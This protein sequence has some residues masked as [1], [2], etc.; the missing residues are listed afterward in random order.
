MPIIRKSFYKEFLIGNTKR[1][2]YNWTFY[3]FAN[4][5]TYKSILL[6]RHQNSSIAAVAENLLSLLQ[7]QPGIKIIPK[8]EQLGDKE[9]NGW[10][11]RNFQVTQSTWTRKHKRK[12]KFNGQEST[13]YTIDREGE[14][15]TPII[16]SLSIEKTQDNFPIVN[17]FCNSF[18]VEGQNSK[19]CILY[20]SFYQF[21]TSSF[22]K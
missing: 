17:I 21:I 3:E 1:W 15:D 13:H 12:R 11:L 8:Q 20:N 9:M 14:V 16:V 18:L 22:T 10:Y 2:I 4:F 19:E 7:Q 6:K 5:F